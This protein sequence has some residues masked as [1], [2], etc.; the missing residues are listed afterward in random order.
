MERRDVDELE[1]HRQVGQL[2]RRARLGVDSARR[3]EESVPAGIESPPPVLRH[4]PLR[5]QPRAEVGEGHVAAQGQGVV[6]ALQRPGGESAPEGLPGV[7]LDTSAGHAPDLDVGVLPRAV[8][9]GGGDELGD[10]RGLAALREGGRTLGGGRALVAHGASTATRSHLDED[11]RAADVFEREGG[12]PAQP[13][14]DR[15]PRGRRPRARVQSP[16]RAAQQGHT[17]PGAGSILPS[18]STRATSAPRR[19][20]RS[21]RA[22]SSRAASARASLDPTPRDSSGTADPAARRRA[23]AS[24]PC[25]KARAAA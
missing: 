8:G 25:S 9:G 17:A 23:P 4:H 19:S 22:P 2:S 24:S 20:K 12:G 18:T 6:E 11:D 7:A 16:Q 15:E 13:E 3:A 1:P 14:V 10:R 21:S 5:A